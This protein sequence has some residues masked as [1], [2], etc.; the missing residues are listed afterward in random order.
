MTSGLAVMGGG[1]DVAESPDSE[2]GRRGAA[3]AACAAIPG[4]CDRP[5]P[6]PGRPESRDAIL[7]RVAATFSGSKPRAERDPMTSWPLMTDAV[8]LAVGSGEVRIRRGGGHEVR[9][10]LLRQGALG[11]RRCAEDQHSRR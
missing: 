5:P 2:T 7:P 4:P 11:S 10:L 3:A 9:L 6:P 1:D 8:A